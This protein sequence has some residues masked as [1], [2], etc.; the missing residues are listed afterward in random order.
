MANRKTITE[1][2]RKCSEDTPAWCKECPFYKPSFG[3]ISDLMRAALE[4]IE[5]GQQEADRWIPVTER[6]PEEDGE[7]LV[8]FESGYAEDYDFDPIGIA[9]FEVDCEGFGIWQERFHPVSL[10]SLGSEWVDIPV[11]AWRPLPEAFEV[12]E[13]A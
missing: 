10:G 9:P 2:L 7:Y 3:C 4:L 8:T 5:G 12:E 13:E 6:L 1:W 11:T